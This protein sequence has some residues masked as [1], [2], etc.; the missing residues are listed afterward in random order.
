MSV[1]VDGGFKKW[2]RVDQVVNVV[3][4]QPSIFAS[5]LPPITQQGD[6]RVSAWPL[7][8]LSQMFSDD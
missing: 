3:D 1:D 8:P 4:H 2:K 7:F 6:E 5:T